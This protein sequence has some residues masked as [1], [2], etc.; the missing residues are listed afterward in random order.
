VAPI[1]DPN[2][3]LK[4][5]VNIGNAGSFLVAETLAALAAPYGLYRCDGCRNAYTPDRRP[6]VNRHRWCPSCRAGG[7]RES[8]RISRQ[9]SVQRLQKPNV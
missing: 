3:S 8:R 9:K 2:G 5:T 6:Q 4:V 1:L 7:Y